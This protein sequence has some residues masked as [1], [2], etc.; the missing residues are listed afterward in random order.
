[1]EI[2]NYGLYKTIGMTEK[3]SILKL[4]EK[5]KLIFQYPLYWYSF[6]FTET[7]TVGTISSQYSLDKKHICAIAMLVELKDILPKEYKLFAKDKEV[8]N[9]SYRIFIG[10]AINEELAKV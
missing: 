7:S 4:L 10:N 3:L 5:S 6:S 1:M 8:K 9:P 2:Q